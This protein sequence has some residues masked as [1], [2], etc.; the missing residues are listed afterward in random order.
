MKSAIAFGNIE[1]K[2]SKNEF[3]RLQ[4]QTNNNATMWYFQ[5]VGVS[6]ILGQLKK[7][8]YDRN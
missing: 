7:A 4:P 8:T 1:D 3:S 6:I 2:I 5:G